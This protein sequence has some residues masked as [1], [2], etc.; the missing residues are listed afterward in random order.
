MH[1]TLKLGSANAT[2]H[3]PNSVVFA[4]HLRF[5]ILITNSSPELSTARRCSSGLQK[6]MF[7]NRQNSHR[8][9]GATNNYMTGFSSFYNNFCFT[10]T[11]ERS[12]F[13]FRTRLRADSG[14]YSLVEI[15]HY[16]SSTSPVWGRG[17][18]SV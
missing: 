4:Q 3:L 10:A 17:C 12:Y 8:I 6:T 14:L 18:G 7:A 9:H 16:G 5:P 15:L 11:W 2:L 1:R 13:K